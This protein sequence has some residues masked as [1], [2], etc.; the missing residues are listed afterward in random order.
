MNDII[1]NWSFSN[2]KNRGSM[3]YIIAISI[4]IGLIIWGFLTRQYV[5][6]FLIILITGVSFFIEN[7]S[8]ENT[9]IYISNLGIKINSSF[10]DFSKIAS[11]SFIYDG[12]YAIYLRLALNQRGI[13]YLDL[14]I[15]NNIAGILKNILPN[16]ISEDEK[17]ELSFT[18]KLI[19]ILKL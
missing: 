7:N 15:D 14:D 18:D 6:S 5:M 3:W 16:F 19:K 12:E 2:D 1:Y 13:K 9:D 17:A 11:Y 10:Y 4:I 8:Q